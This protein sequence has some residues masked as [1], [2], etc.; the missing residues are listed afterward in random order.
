MLSRWTMGAIASKKARASSPVSSRIAVARAGEVRGP[1]ATMTLSHSAGG[2]PAISSRAIVDQR[3]R[4]QRRLDRAGEPVP[5]HRQRAARGH[6]VLIRRPQ[7]E[8]A[9]APH[10]LMQHAHRIVAGIV[11]A[12]RVGADELR[13]PVGLMRLGPA[14]RPH[15]VQHHGYASL[16]HLPRRLAAGKAAADDVDGIVGVS[17]VAMIFAIKL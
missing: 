2:R 4:R 5:I 11:G 8:G 16:G 10:L 7:D 15:L 9:A 13:E 12:E 3:M 14:H 6:L 17:H 1:V